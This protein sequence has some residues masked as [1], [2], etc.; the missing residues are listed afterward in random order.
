MRIPFRPDDERR[1]LRNGLRPREKYNMF[2][3][4]CQT[5]Y[6][7]RLA[8]AGTE[9]RR[10]PNADRRP[11]Q[12][13]V[14]RAPHPALPETWQRSGRSTTWAE[15]PLKPDEP[16][17]KGKGT[18]SAVPA[19]LDHPPIHMRPTIPAISGCKAKEP[20]RFSLL[21]PEGIYGSLQFRRKTVA[22]RQASVRMPR[23]AF[24]ADERD[25]DG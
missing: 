20:F 19:N 23:Q 21:R 6:V 18:P 13:A 25:A 11:V 3:V 15:S 10:R 5:Y 9:Q 1:K 22:P 2:G 16:E 7:A 14:A 24:K 4:V 8:P 17:P 12:P